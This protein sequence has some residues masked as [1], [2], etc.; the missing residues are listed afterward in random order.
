MSRHAASSLDY[1]LHFPAD[2]SSS[3]RQFAGPVSSPGPKPRPK[4]VENARTPE[5]TQQVHLALSQV[6][7]TDAVFRFF[8]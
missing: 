7:D 2:S 6:T 4:N 1:V 8:D 5:A 3:P